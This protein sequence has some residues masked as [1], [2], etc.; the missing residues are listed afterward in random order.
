MK[1]QRNTPSGTSTAGSMRIGP[2]TTKGPYSTTKHS[3]STAT[4]PGADDALALPSR[5]GDQLLHRNGRITSFS[6]KKARK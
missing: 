2:T 3:P 6:T 4:R 1:L 5:I